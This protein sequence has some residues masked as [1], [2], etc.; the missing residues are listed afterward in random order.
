LE[1]IFRLALWACVL[2]I[3]M[4]LLAGYS[5]VAAFTYFTRKEL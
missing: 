1:P 4:T 3:T 2:F 5:Q